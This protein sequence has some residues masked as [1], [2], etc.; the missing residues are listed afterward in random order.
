MR[1]AATVAI[2]LALG[3]GRTAW[4][5]EEGAA[6]SDPPAASPD[7]RARDDAED[8]PSYTSRTVGRAAVSSA[9]AATTIDLTRAHESVTAVADVVEDAPGVD[10]R[11][12]GG[13]AAP[14]YPAIRGSSPEQVRVFFDGVPLDGPGEPAFDLGAIPVGLLDSVVVHRAGVPLHLGAPGAGGALELRSRFAEADG[15]R[16]AASGGSFATRVLDIAGQRSTASGSPTMA[17]GSYFGSAGDFAY[18]D[19]GGT[20]LERADDRTSR[21]RNAAV[22]R[23]ALLLRH[24]RRVGP[25]RLTAVGLGGGGR[26][27]VPGSSSLAAREASLVDWRGVAAMRLER[28]RLVRD[29]LDLAVRGSVAT[30]GSRFDNPDAELGQA[31]QATRDRTISSFLALHPTWRPVQ[32]LEVRTALE[33]S[34]GR[35]APHDVERDTGFRVAR[36][37]AIASGAE[38][39]WAGAGDWLAVYG[40]GR[41]ESRSD[42]VDGGDLGAAGAPDL[43]GSG[44]G[45]L[46]VTP[47]TVGAVDTAVH[48]VGSA[49]GRPPAFVE[50]Y[51]ARG[52]AVGNPDLR[53]EIR[54]GWDAAAS[55]RWTGEGGRVGVE[56]GWFD[57]HVRQLIAWVETGQG[58]RVPRNLDAA[59]IRGHELAL[60]AGWSDHLDAT[61]SYTL[62]DA[63]NRSPGSSG[64]RLPF[65]ARH[66]LSTTLGVGA[67]PVRAGWESRWTSSMFVD[68]ANLAPAPGHVEHAATLRL[69][70]ERHL[71]AWTLVARLDNM[72]DAR[73]ANIDVRDG[74]GTRAVPAAVSDFL[75]HPLPG[76][77]FYATL[78]YA[79]SP[80]DD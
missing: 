41:V 79:H 77:A 63:R 59:R 15:L 54:A 55:M 24:A 56:Y 5:D 28:P 44:H 57:R 31:A 80:D 45:G 68:E 37:T 47:Q 20:E 48:L 7:E 70:D 14:A 2:V 38:L 65:R 16:V 8:E 36:R 13:P 46:T 18:F 62:L 21:R 25:W 32:S 29:R 43:L 50:L 6:A 64:A 26:R 61:G 74:G 69:H 53:P 39:R 4:A 42:A 78:T 51:G 23:G 58:A 73:T 19:D 72:L 34:R 3:L 10:V 49:A 9:P 17:I 1:L 12:G 71:P 60:S 67:G 11:R 30:A 66:L 22:D 40:N 35:Y 76:R 33:L 75:Y 27:G 52:D